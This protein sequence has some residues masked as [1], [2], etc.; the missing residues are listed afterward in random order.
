MAFRPTHGGGGVFGNDKPQLPDIPY[1]RIFRWSAVI[2]GIIILFVVLNIAKNV[3]TDWLWFR[4]V[5]YSGVFL[6]VLTTKLWLGAAGAAL[7]FSLLW[8]NLRIA[9]RPT[10][11]T[12]VFQGENLL[13]IPD[14]HLVE[15]LVN[16]ILP[17]G[18]LLISVFAGLVV[19]NALWEQVLLYL[20]P[21]D[22]AQNDPLFNNDLGFYVFQFPLLKSLYRLFMMAMGLCVILCAAAYV[23]DGRVAVTEHRQFIAL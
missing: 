13:A 1:Q 21:T 6:T 22:F 12:L 8:V 3:Y 9:R 16:R 10:H 4:Q 18:V 15:P 5:Q 20:H 17:I 2:A 19:A 11:T 23:F 7:V 14:R